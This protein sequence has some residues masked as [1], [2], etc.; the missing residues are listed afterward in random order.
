MSEAAAG[1]THWQV[2]GRGYL[3]QSKMKKKKEKVCLAAGSLDSLLRQQHVMSV[4]QSELFKPDAHCGR[5]QGG[6]INL[7]FRRDNT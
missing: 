5:F 1:A 6:C 3:Q 7:R 2:Q 4:D